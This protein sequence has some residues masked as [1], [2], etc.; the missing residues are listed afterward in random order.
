MSTCGSGDLTLGDAGPD[1]V[2]GSPCAAIHCGT[3]IERSLSSGLQSGRQNVSM[4]LTDCMQPGCSELGACERIS[5][6]VWACSDARLRGFGDRVGE[7]QHGR[8]PG[9]GGR[10]VISRPPPRS[11]PISGSRLSA[12]LDRRGRPDAPREA[13]LDGAIARGD[14]FRE[15]TDR[16]E[17]GVS[18]TPVREALRRVAD[19]GLV[20]KTAHSGSIVASRRCLS[21]AILALYVVVAGT[22]APLAARLAAQRRPEGL[23]EDLRRVHQEMVACVAYLVPWESLPDLNLEFHRKIRLSTATATSSV[24]CSRSSTPWQAP[25]VHAEHA[26]PWRKRPTGNTGP[27]SRPSPCRIRRR[28]RRQPTTLLH[29]RDA[30]IRAMLPSSDPGSGQQPDRLRL[31]RGQPGLHAGR[32]ALRVQPSRSSELGQITG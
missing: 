24:S 14:L 23:I 17:L 8:Q 32:T 2:P 16:A 10:Q 15:D 29:A 6:V 19:E 5:T 12:Q 3:V 21:N 22:V 27:S 31:D 26:K 9:P 20:T 13:I 25:R 30:R 4:R 11:P 1:D 18:R 28:R 7:G